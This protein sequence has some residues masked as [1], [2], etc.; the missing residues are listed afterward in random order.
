MSLMFSSSS[1]IVAYSKDRVIGRGNKLP[2]NLP[3]DLEYFK[4]VTLGHPVIMGYNTFK[5]I[6]KP[7]ESRLNIVISTKNRKLPENVIKANSVQHAAYLADKL[8]P[9]NEIF[10]IGGESIYQQSLPFVN[11]LYVTEIHKKL[12][13]DKFFPE[14]DLDTFEE[15]KRTNNNENKTKFDFVIYKRLIHENNE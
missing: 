6:G 4:K 5:S 14:V 2:W 7:L 9:N 1:I 3:S 8:E 12:K 13:G 15:V 10:F 11:T